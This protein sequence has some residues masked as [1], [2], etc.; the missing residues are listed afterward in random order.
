M[1][2]SNEWYMIRT[3]EIPLNR[4]EPYRVLIARTTIVTETQRVVQVL[5]PYCKKFNLVSHNAELCRENHRH[6]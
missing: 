2:Q 3:K 5:C 1:G 4:A 6:R